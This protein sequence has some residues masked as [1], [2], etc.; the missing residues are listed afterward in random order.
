VSLV[1]RPLVRVAGAALLVV[2]LVA[3]CGP[4]PEVDE[5]VAA[6]TT[7]VGEPSTEEGPD[8]TATPADAPTA[9]PSAVFGAF[10]RSPVA[11]P[12]DVLTLAEQLCRTRPVP[13][14]ADEIGSRPLVVSDTRGL[15]VVILVFAD[16]AGATG[17][18]VEVDE[19]G[20]MTAS[21]FAVDAS[22][23]GPLELGDVTLGA[24]EFVDE[25]ANQRVIA[26]GRVGDG[27]K[28]VDAGFADDTFVYST[29]DN[30]WYAMWWPGAIKPISVVAVDN[31]NIVMGS[32]APP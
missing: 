27:A 20:G 1:R 2:G 16:A 18:R 7:D 21:H 26:V 32:L 25:G 8:A 28:R 11:V 12:P 5:P 19:A 9:T 31:K 15:G 23:E 13:A 29:K 17:C 30:G 6:A 3:A 14:Y 10:R 4:A 22:P 24:L